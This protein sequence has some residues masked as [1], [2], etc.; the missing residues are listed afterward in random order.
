MACTS[1]LRVRKTSQL[2]GVITMSKVAVDRKF[3][4][5]R[6]PSGQEYG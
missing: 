1:L 5:V 4:R 6:I 2:E 3:L